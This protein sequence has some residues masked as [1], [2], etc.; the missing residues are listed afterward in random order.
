MGFEDSVLTRLR[1]YREEADRSLALMR[2][3]DDT[4]PPVLRET[5]R[6]P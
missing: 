4:H 5:F 1:R 2:E 3:V 6:W